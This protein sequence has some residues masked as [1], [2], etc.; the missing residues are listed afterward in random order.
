MLVNF[1]G[2]H[3]IACLKIDMKSARHGHKKF[4]SNGNVHV[5]KTV[6]RRGKNGDLKVY[7]ILM[8]AMVLLVTMMR[9]RKINSKF[10]L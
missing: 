4:L 5:E 1:R 8:V 2:I 9:F 3:V 7:G 6:K 10:G